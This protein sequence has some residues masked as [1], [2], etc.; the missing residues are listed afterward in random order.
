MAH[1][2]DPFEVIEGVLETPKC[3]GEI[4]ANG[5]SFALDLVNHRLFL[6]NSEYNAARK[7][8]AT[9]LHGKRD[10]CEGGE[11]QGLSTT[12]S[13][14]RLNMIDYL[15]KHR[16]RTCCSD[17]HQYPSAF[18]PS[19]S[20]AGRLSTVHRD[21]SAHIFKPKG[22][23]PLCATLDEMIALPIE[24]KSF[25]QLLAGVRNDRTM[26]KTLVD[27][28]EEEMEKMEREK[29]VHADISGADYYA[30]SRMV[31]P[32][33]MIDCPVMHQYI[34]FLLYLNYRIKDDMI[35]DYRVS[36]EAPTTPHNAY[37]EAELNHLNSKGD[38][39]L[40]LFRRLDR[41]EIKRI[42]RQQMVREMNVK[43]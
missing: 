41:K 19:V 22:E 23:A 36:I 30:S 27:V 25:G 6:K 18:S 38:D 5:A 29:R 11:T 1:Y 24:E 37:T 33:L 20:V 32:A 7:H 21:H 26:L 12:L 39:K 3:V 28:A 17:P 34:D 13:G 15:T 43:K 16:R 4:H 10:S 31:E 8:G 14:D 9:A 2:H 42:V 35:N 40:Y